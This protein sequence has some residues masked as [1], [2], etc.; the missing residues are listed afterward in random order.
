MFKIITDI[1]A[2]L[3]KN[4]SIIIG[5]AESVLKAIAAII[6]LTPTKKDDAIYNVVNTVF[7]KIKK[8]LYDISDKLANRTPNS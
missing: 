1:L 4:I 3:V 8:F 7:S 2:Y 5:I 6:S